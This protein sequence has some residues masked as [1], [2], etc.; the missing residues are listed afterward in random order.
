[1]ILVHNDLTKDPTSRNFVH[2]EV[3]TQLHSAT[4]V[5]YVYVIIIL[6]Q[7]LMMKVVTLD[8]CFNA[9]PFYHVITKKSNNRRPCQ[10]LDQ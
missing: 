3:H 8:A 1:M 6:H 10:E 9:Y 2:I 7:I 4:L 5:V